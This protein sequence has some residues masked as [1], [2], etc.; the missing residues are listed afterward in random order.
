M[1]EEGEEEYHE[2]EESSLD[3]ESIFGGIIADVDPGDIVA[4]FYLL[5]RLMISDFQLLRCFESRS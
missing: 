2:L 1:E 4:V 5:H 3:L